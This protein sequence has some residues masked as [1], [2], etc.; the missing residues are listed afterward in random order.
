M[1]PSSPSWIARLQERWQ[2]HSAWQVFIILLVFACTG[3]TVLWLKKPILG[4]L[5]SDDVVGWQRN[6][7]YTLVI[8]PIYQVVLLAYGWLFGQ[9]RFFWNFEKRM[10]ARLLGRKAS[11]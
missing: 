6:L 1:K 3:F 5:L 2:V 7:I 9:F 11:E 10:F 8:L 4:V